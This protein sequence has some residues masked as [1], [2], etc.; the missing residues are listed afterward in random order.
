MFD[1]VK[2]TSFI[3][4]GFGTTS[5]SHWHTV[6]HEHG[7]AMADLVDQVNPYCT[8]YASKS[9]HGEGKMGLDYNAA[10]KVRLTPI[11]AIV[12]SNLDYRRSNRRPSKEWILSA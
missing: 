8:I 1:N 7:T 10:I 9:H 6:S 11:Y 12:K 2:G 4:D 5:E 3:E